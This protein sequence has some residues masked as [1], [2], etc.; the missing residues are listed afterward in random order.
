MELRASYV[1]LLTIAALSQFRVIPHCHL[2]IWQDV[3]LFC[4]IAF[5]LKALPVLSI[6][7][8]GG[9]TI[10]INYNLITNSC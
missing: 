9:L 10:D 3:Y 8:V 1:S 2:Y 4:S 6:V 5:E 7:I